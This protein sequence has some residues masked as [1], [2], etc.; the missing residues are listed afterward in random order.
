MKKVV[1]ALALVLVVMTGQSQSFE[2]I[3]RWSMNMEITDPKL[4]AQMEEMA[5]LMG[6]KGGL[7]GM[8]PTGITIMLKGPNSLTKVEGG[9]MDKNDVLYLADKK[10]TYTIM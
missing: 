1:L 5:K 3:I 2:G 8:M 6:D 9:I 7:N 10:T 4:K